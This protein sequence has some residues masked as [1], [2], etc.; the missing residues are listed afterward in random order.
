MY[1][2]ILVKAIYACSERF[3][4]VVEGCRIKGNLLHMCTAVPPPRSFPYPATYFPFTEAFTLY[5][6]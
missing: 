6:F 1:I 2:D 5:T 3:W 4:E